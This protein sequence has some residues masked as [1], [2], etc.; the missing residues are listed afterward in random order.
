LQEVEEDTLVWSVVDLMTLLLVVFILFY[1]QA[2]GRKPD[3][4]SKP[5]V[6]QSTVPQEVAAPAA[7][8]IA[9]KAQA[10]RKTQEAAP[11]T[12]LEKEAFIEEIRREVL[13]PTGEIEEQGVSVRWSNHQL[14]FVLG[15]KITFNVGEAE[16]LEAFQPTLE[17]I[18]RFIAGKPQTL[19]TVA[20]HTDDRP[21][22]TL[23][24]PS[25][26]ELSAARA[27]TVAKFLT[28]HD[29]A[30]ARITVQGHGEYRPLYENTSP[31][32]RQANRRVEITLVRE[33][34]QVSDRYERR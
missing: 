5:L 19:I 3:V 14:V 13:N 18:A 21:I 8:P 17:R 11:M 6:S 2:I 22:N 20:G 4:A 7:V 31:E 16:L 33:K 28:E 25:N 29:V 10:P 12:S 1:T 27:V 23:L 24:F 9:R 15:E 30:P 26:W 32:N 34:P